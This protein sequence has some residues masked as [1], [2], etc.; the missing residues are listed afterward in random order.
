MMLVQCVLMGG[1]V[2]VA[3]VVLVVL[4]LT[5]VE[6]GRLEPRPREAGD[7]RML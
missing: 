3:D 7:G 6:S 1:A 2:F 5:T 4:Y